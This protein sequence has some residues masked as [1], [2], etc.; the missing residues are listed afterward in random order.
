VNYKP[1]FALGLAV[2][3]GC[4]TPSTPTLATEQPELLRNDLSLRKV[5]ALGGGF[6][7]LAHD[8]RTGQL[9]Y[10]NPSGDLYAI[11]PDEKKGTR[12]HTSREVLGH[13][14]VA[15]GMTIGPDG[16]IYA[17]C[18]SKWVG[19]NTARVRKGVLGADGKRTW[20]TL[21]QTEPYPIGDTQFDHDFN[22]LAVS[23]N[24]KWLYVNSGSRTD[25]G[26]VQDAKGLWPR[27]R[28]LALTAT[29]F[30]IP[31]SA[32]KTI[33]LA[34]DAA[35]LK[36]Y[37]F[38]QGT[39]NCYDLAFAANGDL[40]CGEN[41]PDADYPDE[42]NWLREGRHYG[43]PWR[44]GD[45]DNAVTKPGYA[46]S[47][48]K[49]L[50]EDFF[51]VANKLYVFEPNFPPPPSGVKFTNPVANMGP[52]ADSYRKADGGEGDA[53]REGKP[54]LGITP[55]RSPLGLVFDAANAL[56]GDY[57]GGLFVLS[58]GSAGG[59]LRDMGQDLLLMKPVKRGDNYAATMTQIARNFARP[60]D[61]VL[62]GKKLYVLEFEGEGAIWEIEFP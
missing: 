17:T 29:V 48:D 27:L 34:N 35:R 37:V 58:W 1:L 31:T 21:M 55:H 38:A 41:A 61:A 47:A 10:M 15:T 4:G 14:C 33:V 20:Q 49:K 59:T 39:R 51:A 9:I 26:E 6:I 57:K 11:K 32:A 56:S 8:A 18:N 43:F 25:H 23:P 2:L 19:T 50:H 42:I 52:D 60:I 24:G 53:S 36:P 62:V 28:E 7:R 13:D 22:G 44:L 40:F 3:I 45:E 30:R 12:L 46:P 5:T 16:A 54:L